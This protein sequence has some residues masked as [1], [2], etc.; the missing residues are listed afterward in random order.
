MIVISHRG[1][2]NGPDPLT[3]NSPAQID[4]CI[5]KGYQVEIDLWCGVDTVGMYLG[6]DEPQYPIN[7]Q[8]LSSRWSHLWI[9]CKNIE[10]LIHLRRNAPHMQFFWHQ[11]DDYTL[12]S[13]GW[14]WAYPNMNVLFDTE[15]SVCVMP[16]LNNTDS[17]NFEAVCT[18]YAE[19]YTI[20]S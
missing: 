12:T 7:H 5:E 18:D 6:H 20:R 17:T 13:Q 10:A 2:L 9:H 1:N 14:I 11:E 3:E 16:E 15:K 4:K 8:W 19:T